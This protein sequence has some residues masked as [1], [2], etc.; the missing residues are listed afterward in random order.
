MQSQHTHINKTVTY[1][2]SILRLILMRWDSRN[3]SCSTKSTLC[4]HEHLDQL[5]T[6][7]FLS[8]LWHLDKWR[9]G[10]KIALPSNSLY[11]ENNQEYLLD[12]SCFSFFFSLKRSNNNSLLFSLR[13]KMSK[14]FSPIV[15]RRKMTK[16]IEKYLIF[17][18]IPTIS[19]HPL[20]GL[21]LS[22]S[23]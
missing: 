21:S 3:T 15:V 18:F 23:I 11:G 22:L 14:K 17:L 1:H 12:Y 16:T 8:I 10:T 7:V 6:I 5:Q 9:I 20:I 4:L 2:I 19:L 13:K